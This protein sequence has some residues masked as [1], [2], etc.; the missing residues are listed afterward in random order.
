MAVLLRDAKRSFGE[1]RSQTEFGNESEKRYHN[2][3]SPNTARRGSLTPPPCPTAGLKH[4]RRARAH[5]ASGMH[6]SLIPSPPVPDCH[7]MSLIDMN[8]IEILHFTLDRPLSLSNNV[9]IGLRCWPAGSRRP[10]ARI[11]PCTSQP[12]PL[13]IRVPVFAWRRSSSGRPARAAPRLGQSS[14]IA[15]R[16]QSR[17]IHAHQRI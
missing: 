3:F 14:M 4:P 5:A 2:W 17:L 10:S 7:R 12:F 11:A 6:P 15:Y 13:T 8:T 9:R 16:C 1:V